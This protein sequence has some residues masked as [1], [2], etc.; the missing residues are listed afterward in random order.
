MNERITCSNA[1]KMGHHTISFASASKHFQI[2]LNTI[3][4][5]ETE[6]SSLPLNHCTAVFLTGLNVYVWVNLSPFVVRSVYKH[7]HV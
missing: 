5:F 1:M 3:F 4:P 6:L 7:P 2:Q